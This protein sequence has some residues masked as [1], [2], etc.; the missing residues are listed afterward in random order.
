L[1]LDE[2][3]GPIIRSKSK[4]FSI[5]RI[6]KHI[7]R[8]SLDMADRNEQ[9]RDEHHEERQGG[10][11]YAARNQENLRFKNR[12][13]IRDSPLNLLG[14]QHDLHVLP[15]GTLKKFYG[16]GA[17]DAKRHMHLFLD[18]YDFHHVEYDNVMVRLFLQTL[19]RRAYEW[20]T[21]FPDRSICSFN[22]LED[23]FLM[24]F[25]PPIAYHILLTDF[26]Q[27]GF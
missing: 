2:Y 26:T 1:K 6:E 21:T 7:P 3:K 8:I 27:I 17:I 5:V 24:M 25:A 15:K 14:E 10:E 20:Y 11:R 22:D 13:R 9:P 19:S 12:R 23:M 4:Q 16:D 18:V